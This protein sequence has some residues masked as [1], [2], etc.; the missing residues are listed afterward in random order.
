MATLQ[1]DMFTT[2]AEAHEH[3]HTDTYI[4]TCTVCKRTSKTT[5]DRVTTYG[6][7]RFAPC[8]QGCTHR[9]PG[10]NRDGKRASVEYHQIQGT[11]NPRIRCG[12]KCQTATGRIC[13]CSCRGVNHGGR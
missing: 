8:P 6:S 12:F 4:G 3:T 5:G 1:L 13:E 2:D 11:Y 7:Q 10:T 9:A